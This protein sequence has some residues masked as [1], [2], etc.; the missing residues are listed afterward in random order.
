MKSLIVVCVLGVVGCKQ[1]GKEPATGSAGSASTGSASAGS[2]TVGSGGSATAGSAAGCV[3]TVA[4]KPGS[5]TYDG[6][7]IAGNVDRK[8]GEAPN[9]DVLKPL[10]AKCSAFVIA[11]PTLLYQ[12]VI[13][14]MDTLVKDGIVNVSLGKPG[15]KPPAGGDRPKRA[16]LPPDL[17]TSEWKTDASGKLVL[18][19]AIKPQPAVKAR[20]RDVP[21][22]VVTKTQVM[23]HGE[24]VAKPDDTAL[25]TKV[26]AVLPANPK[27]PTLILQADAQTPAATIN[28]II[29]AANNQGYTELLFAVKKQ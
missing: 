2:S 21:V 12:D 26:A 17:I 24:E 1:G 6:G 5:I 10:A 29:A 23:F 27:D 18:E 19:G 22:V 13:T 16:D 11:D 4:I 14:V 9:L 7:G 20:L 3:I 25:D 28:G 8:P 15:D